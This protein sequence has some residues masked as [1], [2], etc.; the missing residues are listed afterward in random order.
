MGVALIVASEPF[1]K[2]IS[3]QVSLTASIT[4]ANARNVNKIINLME[5]F[6]GMFRRAVSKSD[7][8]MVYASNANRNMNMLDSAAFTKISQSLG[9]TSTTTKPNA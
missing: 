3:V 2:T 9:A 1:L 6:V 5:M 4:T 7:N 8:Q